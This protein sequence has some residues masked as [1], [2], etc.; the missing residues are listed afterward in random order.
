[1]SKPIIK[2]RTFWVNALVVVAAGLA[3]MVDTSIIQQ[4]PQLV[5]YG[6]AFLGVVNVVLRVI[7]KEP[8]Q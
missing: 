6:V 8:I 7:T 3:A 1:M 2:S 5:A 4:N